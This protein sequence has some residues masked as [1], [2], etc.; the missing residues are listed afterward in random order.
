MA[1]SFSD[2]AKAASTEPELDFDGTLYRHSKRP[3][4]GVAILAWDHGDVRAYQFEDGRLRK[5]K[6][7]FFKLMKPVE[8]IRG[9]R[10]RL[11]SD[12]TE[13]VLSDDDRSSRNSELEPVAPFQAQVDLFVELYPEGFADEA[14]VKE[15]RGTEKGSDL[16]RHRDPVIQSVR[17]K[18][19]A[20]A[21]QA[22]MEEERY[23]E[24]VETVVEILS[25]TSLVELKHVRLLKGLEAEETK[26]LAGAIA[27]LLHGSEVYSRRFRGYLRVLR[28]ILGSRPSWRLATALPALAFPQEHVCVRR[29]AFKRQA[30]AIAPRARYSR[31]TRVRPYENYRQVALEVRRRLKEAGH[32]PRDLLDVHD[33]VWA[34]LRNAALEHLGG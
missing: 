11:V 19:S 13:Q 18:L 10:E 24:L 32:E 8:D 16:K 26:A 3:Q 17:E 23:G 9:S 6:E 21:C 4:W 15:H 22:M 14:W 34:T 1:I 30:A 12:L 29:S 25:S 7:G 28:D 27:N 5:F 2:A 33:F 20:E 31:N